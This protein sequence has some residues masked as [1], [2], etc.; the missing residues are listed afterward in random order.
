MTDL[1]QGNPIQDIEAKPQIPTSK[2]E[3][4]NSSKAI[5]SLLILIILLLSTLLG[6]FLVNYYST[7][8]GDSE[9]QTKTEDIVDEE[10]TVTPTVSIEVGEIED[11]PAGWVPFETVLTCKPAYDSIIEISG[12]KPQE[13]TISVVDSLYCGVGIDDYLNIESEDFRFRLMTNV[14]AFSIAYFDTMEIQTKNLGNIFRF[15]SESGENYRS[16]TDEYQAEGDCQ[17]IFGLIKSPCGIGTLR[18]T[19]VDCFPENGNGLA[20]CDDIVKSLKVEFV[21]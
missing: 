13:A 14:E 3:T 4:R 5:I 11:I 16:Y 12:I 7:M 15:K 2:P 6:I 19:M 9:L 18:E 17:G 8:E 10:I 1:N 20:L 21:N